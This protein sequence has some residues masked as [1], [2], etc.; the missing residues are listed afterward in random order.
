[1]NVFWVAGGTPDGTI[2]PEQE[3]SFWEATNVFIRTIMRVIEDKLV[4][5][6]LHIWVAKNLWDA[7]KAM[8]SATDVQ[9]ELYDME[10]FHDYGVVENHHVLY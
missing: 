1:M 9:S 8:F 10:Q 2:A 3:N 7:L 4:N 5:P 6:C